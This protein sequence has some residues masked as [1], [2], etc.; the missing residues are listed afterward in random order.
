MI[1]CKMKSCRYDTP[2]WLILL[3]KSFVSLRC[4]GKIIFLYLCFSRIIL[5]KNNFNC[6]FVTPR[7]K[8]FW[9]LFFVVSFAII[10]QRHYCLTILFFIFVT[11]LRIRVSWISMD[12]LTFATSLM[13]KISVLV[14]QDISW[15][16]MERHVQ[17]FINNIIGN[18]YLE[19]DRSTNWLAACIDWKGFSSA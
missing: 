5:L 6:S 14:G 18:L 10:L 15:M 4:P 9:G 1:Q 19:T 12:V 8:P 13:G 16:M 7:L 17:V 11:Q 2:I 3:S